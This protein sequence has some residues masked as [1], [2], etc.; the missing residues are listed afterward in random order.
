[1]A[2]EAQRLTT[3]RDAWLLASAACRSHFEA[4][5]TIEAATRHY[6]EVFASVAAAWW[7]AT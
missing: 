3:D 5:H 6:G 1:M 7:R 2:D 4:H